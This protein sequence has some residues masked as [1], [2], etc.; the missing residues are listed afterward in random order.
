LLIVLLKAL[1]VLSDESRLLSL[2]DLR[3][4][5]VGADFS[6]ARPMRIAIDENELCEP[7]CW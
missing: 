4:G 1:K 2:L 7:C 3:P 5:P 6:P